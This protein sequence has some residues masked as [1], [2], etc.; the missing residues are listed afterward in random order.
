VRDRVVELAGD[1]HALGDDG[2]PGIARAGALDPIRPLARL[3]HEPP[4][5]ADDPPDGPG[6]GGGAEQ[7]DRHR[8]GE[9]D[10]RVGGGAGRE[11]GDAGGRVTPR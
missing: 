8:L 5:P 9:E 11:D 7:R 1:A 3:G 4:L 6:H 2:G 10:G